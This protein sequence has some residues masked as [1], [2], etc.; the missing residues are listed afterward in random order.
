M[1]ILLKVIL[2]LP[3]VITPVKRGARNPGR[4]AAV[5]PIDM[6]KPE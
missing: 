4:L 2:T 3:W 5:F 1:A 6:R